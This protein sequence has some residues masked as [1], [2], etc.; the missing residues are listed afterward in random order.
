MSQCKFLKEGDRNTRYFHLVATIRR[1][2]KMIE[3]I[4]VNGVEYTDHGNINGMFGKGKRNG[5]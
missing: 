3:R 4:V 5:T 2:K 1:K